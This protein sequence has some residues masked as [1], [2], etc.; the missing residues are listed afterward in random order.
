M[1]QNDRVFE[2]V[3]IAALVIIGSC[4]TNKQAVPVDDTIKKFDAATFDYLYV[5]ALKQRLL[6]NGGDAL[7][8]LEQCVKLN[9]ASD[10]AY[11]QMGQI[12]LASGDLVNGKKY[13]GKAL[14]LDGRNIWYIMMLSGIHYKE[15][16]IDSAIIV[17]EKTVEY[18]PEKVSFQVN[19][20]NMY[21]ENK[22]YEKSM[23]IFEML[24]EKYGLNETATYAY[25][26]ILLK[27]E[28]YN[29]AQ[30]KTE[31]L[32][33]EYPSGMQYYAVLAEIL[34]KKGQGEKA[35]EVYKILL[36]E[37]PKNGQI[38]LSLCD[39]LINERRFEDLFMVLNPVILNTEISREGKISLFARLIEVKDHKKD[40]IDRILMSLMVLE[41]TY[42]D[43][44]IIPLLRPE[45]LDN[46]ERD[47]EAVDRLEEIISKKP[48]NYYSWEKLLLLHLKM[49]DFK[50]LMIRGEECASRFNRSFLAKLLYANG[51][52][53]NE[54]Y[55]IALDEL[56]K[57][58]ILSGDNSENII[59]VLT[60][61]ADVYYRMKDYSKAFE[62]FEEALSKDN[63]DLTILNNYAYYLAE[64][65]MKLKE[66]E[67][68]SRK[69]IEKEKDNPTFLDTY[70]WV[71][72]KRGKTK[73]A[74][75]I[76]ESII[77]NGSN[78]HAEYYEHYGFILKSRKKC[79]KAIENW[80]I[81]FK[82]DSTKTELEGEINS[83][84]R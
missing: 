55:E 63:E 43:D 73:D 1:K 53:E 17:Y 19:L 56:R 67:I 76:M 8:Y 36:D 5:E 33:H 70:A 30:K 7:R 37:N 58:Q 2:I 71:L 50:Q 16:N 11:F 74:A 18:Y 66:A 20:A 54:K 60:M 35:R 80:R 34:R 52:I 10:A 21:S 39:L 57:A 83:C 79:D 64:Q 77:R 24:E 15:G 81:A 26:Q 9:P 45:F 27:A 40:D 28:R 84:K 44:D 12:V 75:K 42:S 68:M 51:A 46:I 59:Q 65:N 31:D 6:G 22:D 62:T 25:I 69:V 82:M 23:K 13:A 48:G 72:Y 41:A 61:R 49:G 47:K 32:I 38:Q 78:L 4:A 29:D 3:L 14:H